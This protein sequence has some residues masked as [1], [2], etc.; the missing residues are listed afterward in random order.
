MKRQKRISK[1]GRTYYNYYLKTGKPHTGRPPMEIVCYNK[2]VKNCLERD[3]F[4]CQLC[5]GKKNLNVHHKDMKGHHIQ[6]Y[7]AN[8]NLE[9]L[10]TLCFRCHRL[11]HYGILPKDIIKKDLTNGAYCGMLGA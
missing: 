10:Q 5:G 1:S 2:N 7:E 11:L 8:D 6:K 4:T 9:N 3:N